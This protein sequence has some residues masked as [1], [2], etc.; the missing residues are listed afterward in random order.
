MMYGNDIQAQQQAQA[1]E[2][3]RQQEAL[4][5]QQQEAFARQRAQQAQAAQGPA[6]G[7]DPSMFSSFM[8]GGGGAG[9]AGA[10]S[11]GAGAGGA[12][13]S[14]GASLTSAWPVAVAAL[15]I[16]QHEWAKNKGLHTDMDALTG[17]A[18]LKDSAYYQT[19][20]NEKLGGLGDEMRLASLG[21]SPA[22]LFKG[23]TWKEAGNLAIKGGILGNLLKKI[24]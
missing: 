6:G 4:Q 23:Q 21:S 7:I 1:A 5:Q 17:R 18:L 24:F 14:G 20:G 22:D 16:G 10:G 9:A 19:K 8:G 11:A 2:L 15:A 12:G 3:Q 13:A